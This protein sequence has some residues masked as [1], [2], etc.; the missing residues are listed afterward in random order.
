MTSSWFKKSITISGT[1][2]KKLKYVYVKKSQ[3]MT[4]AN[5]NNKANYIC[6]LCTQTYKEPPS[7]NGSQPG[8]ICVSLGFRKLLHIIPAFLNLRKISEK[9]YLRT[10]NFAVF[11]RKLSKIRS[12]YRF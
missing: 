3:A 5:K 12:E 1:A 7:A 8:S 11:A 10:A 2:S 6:L 4:K 9:N